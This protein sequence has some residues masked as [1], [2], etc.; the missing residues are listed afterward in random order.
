MGKV[1]ES[2][3]EQNGAWWLGWPIL[4]VLLALSGLPM[5]WFP[6]RLPS[7]VIII[8]FKFYKIL[9]IKFF[10]VVEQAAASILDSPGGRTSPL[11]ESTISDV[12]NVGD[13]KY[14][15]SMLRLLNNKILLCSIFSSIFCITG[16][17][18]FLDSEDII[19]ESRFYAPR[20]TGLFLA[21]G[22]P[23]ISRTISSK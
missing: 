10:Q 11:S 9:N 12:K 1:I 13:T 6:R 2:Y 7:E 23:L 21:F 22:D 19:L 14:L 20:P 4:A 15:P 8:Y 5:S 17:I 18:N 3:Q 16:I